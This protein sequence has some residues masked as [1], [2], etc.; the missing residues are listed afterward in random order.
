MSLGGEV[1]EGIFV[2][3]LFA[4]PSFAIALFALALASLGHPHLTRL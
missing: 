4:F 1:E 2:G 3:Y